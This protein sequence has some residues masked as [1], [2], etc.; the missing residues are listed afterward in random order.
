[1]T[2]DQTRN[3]DVVRRE[4]VV[5]VGRVIAALLIIA[6]VIFVF[7]NSQEA[8]FTLFTWRMTMPVYLL[9]AIIFVLGWLGG[10]L[11]KARKV[12]RARK[13]MMDQL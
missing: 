13:A 3:T 8:E 9:A 1:M 4:P 12:R 7:Q 5:T 2:D 11:S 6:L 10:Y